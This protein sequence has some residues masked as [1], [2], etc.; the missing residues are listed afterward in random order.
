LDSIP[1]LSIL[2]RRESWLFHQDLCSSLGK[3]KRGQRGHREWHAIRLDINLEIG[4]RRQGG[5]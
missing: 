1:S 5:E 3:R 2:W 4:I